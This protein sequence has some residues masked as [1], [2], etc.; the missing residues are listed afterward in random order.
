MIFK[1]IKCKK[2]DAGLVEF[3]GQTLTQCV[4]CGYKFPLVKNQSS[5]SRRTRTRSVQ[6]NSVN[7]SLTASPEVRDLIN[8]LKGWSEKKQSTNRTTQSSSQNSTQ[9]NTR[10]AKTP[11]PVSNKK[12]TPIWVTLIKWYIIISV[13][14]GIITGFFK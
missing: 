10:K 11:L 5:V 4:Q 14:I 1:I 8:K 2:C 3:S 6:K 9:S 12:S 7:Q 13:V